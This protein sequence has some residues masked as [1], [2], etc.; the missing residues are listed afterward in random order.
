MAGSKLP[1]LILCALAV[2][3]TARTLSQLAVDVPFTTLRIGEVT[4][5]GSGGIR[6][7]VGGVAPSAVATPDTTTSAAPSKAGKLALR[8][9]Q[10]LK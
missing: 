7:Q 1:I 4:R 2:T 10:L 9:T 8:A 3:C 6:V 5:A